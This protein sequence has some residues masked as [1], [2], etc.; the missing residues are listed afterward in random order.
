MAQNVNIRINA[1][2]NASRVF[3]RIAIA[4]GAFLG[5]RAIG[6]F[7]KESTQE[8]ILQEVATT[9]LEQALRATGHA[10]GFSAKQL[11]VYSGE[12]EKTTT[13][14]ADLWDTS[15]SL[16]ATFRNVSGDIFKESILLV[17]DVSTAMGTDLKSAT[18][19]LGKALN[20]PIAGMSA[21]TRV[22]IQFSQQQKDSIKTFQEQNNIMGA[23]R[24][25]LDELSNQFGGQAKAAV[26]NLEGAIKQLA[27]AWGE[28]KDALVGYMVKS[29]DLDTNIRLVTVL[30][31]NMG[32]TWSLVMKQME[33]SAIKLNN[34]LV[35]WT[36]GDW[37]MGR[38]SGQGTQGG[39][40]AEQQAGDELLAI[41]ERIAKRLAVR[42]SAGIPTPGSGF[43]GGPFIPPP[44]DDPANK[45]LKELKRRQRNQTT[46]ARFLGGGDGSPVRKTNQTLSRIEK[47][48]MNLN[49]REERRDQNLGRRRREPNIE[50]VGSLI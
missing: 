30:I 33:L 43:R 14:A 18:I 26:Q 19:Q 31:E 7:V 42:I 9:K 48:L 10:A 46:E 47:Q 25:I 44:P 15:M 22:G 45:A 28:A 5:F 16:M 17:G 6:R 24:I 49:R 37:M 38:I 40:R 21:L 29:T 39:H 13:I 32:D 36:I 8:W 27:N 11:Q 4:A 3:K 41:Q 1:K 23:Q 12:L 35:D 20:D 34:A 50:V 2:D